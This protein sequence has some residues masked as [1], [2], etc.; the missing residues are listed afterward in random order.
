MLYILDILKQSNDKEMRNCDSRSEVNASD[1]VSYVIKSDNK[2]TEEITI[3]DAR[4][5]R[6]R[7]GNSVTSLRLELGTS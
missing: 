7:L 3:G 1:S 6:A 4:A 2:E 5:N